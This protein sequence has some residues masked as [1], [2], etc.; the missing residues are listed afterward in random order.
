MKPQPFSHLHLQ[1]LALAVALSMTGL[2]LLAPVRPAHAQA[3]KSHDIQAGPLAEALTSLASKAGVALVFN[4]A[5]LQGRVAPEIESVTDVEAGF[6]QLLEGT[7]YTVRKTAGGYVL[8][9]T[10]SPS[11]A[12]TTLAAVLVTSEK[13]DRGFLETTSSVGY[14][15]GQ[16][17]EEA[18]IRNFSDA[19]RLLGNVRDAD[20]VDQGFMI[21]GI[22]SEG[23]GSQFS[24]LATV[25]IDGVA[26]TQ[27]G[28]RRGAT[29]VWDVEKIEVLR[30]PQ[31]TVSGKN[32]LAGTVN[33]KT[34]DPSFVLEGAVRVLAG[35]Y[36]QRG[37]AGMISGPVNDQLAYRLT[38]ES[39]KADGFVKYPGVT[40]PRL[41][42][43]KTDEQQ[44]IRGKLLW[45]SRPV[46]GIRVLLTHSDSKDSPSY[47]S[48]K[49]PGYFNRVWVDANSP[50]ARDTQ[51][52]QTSLEVSWP[53]GEGWKLSSL[54]SK[55]DTDTDRSSVDKVYTVGAFSQQDLAQEI[56]LNYAQGAWKAVAGVYLSRF[57][58][59][60]RV[61]FDLTASM[62]SAF[63]S[64]GR[65]D[66]DNQAAFGELNY[67]T[68]PVTWIVG[69]RS[70]HQKQRYRSSMTID[71]LGTTVSSD[72]RSKSDAFLTKFGAL[73]HLS[74][75]ESLGI[76]RQRGYRA[77]GLGSA[78]DG[79][80]AFAPK[81]HDFTYAD[82][83]ADNTEL[84]YRFV[85]ADERWTVAANVF[86]TD[87]TNQQI[88]TMID[89]PIPFSNIIVN[90]GKSKVKGAE[91]E[92]MGA[93]DEQWN[94]FASVGY[95]ATRFKEFV[96]EGKD[97]AGSAFPQA[98]KWTAVLGANWRQGQW[99]AGGDLKYTG[100]ALS[101][102][103]L[104][105]GQAE[106]L[107]AH[108]VLNLRG[109]YRWGAS[110]L[111][112]QVDN[113]TDEKYF[114]YRNTAQNSATIGKPRMV[115]LVFDHKF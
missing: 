2:A 44:T 1:P 110:S 102:S 93:F 113:A 70:E 105:G 50:E 60:A 14:L 74:E 109:G 67:R 47:N 17:L 8:E 100:R 89:P 35:N 69:G 95:V 20:S 40:G 5:L 31:S 107:P 22:N 106:H 61:D 98:P 85:S 43:R 11:P 29:G 6:R 21:R 49:G 51:V 16:R 112:L 75:Q 55:V 27:Q 45:Q 87:W 3:R 79:L 82:E 7:G 10:Q 71:A 80:M 91:L 42:E 96:A 30:G 65:G 53:L 28:A 68:G 19:F 88:E 32:A 94:L 58:N 41:H 13:I 81:P 114:L 59:A 54:T 97:L 38:V 66:L 78:I 25:N 4:P 76:V 86:Y 39:N 101:S 26:Q 24:P 64:R 63:R 33:I 34:H 90:A 103:V 72:R 36:E 9:S 57:D 92:F 83:K 48:V 115:S 84:S 15:D 99:F 37:V 73:W 111:T 23:M 56:R 52:R 108:T 62:G 12:E 18:G 77:G 104:T 46:D